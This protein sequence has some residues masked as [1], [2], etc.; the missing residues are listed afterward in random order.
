ME[1]G[2]VKGLHGKRQHQQPKRRRWQRS[3]SSTDVRTLWKT[4]SCEDGLLARQERPTGQEGKDKGRGKS[5][6]SKAQLEC[7]ICGKTGYM[8][9]DCRS[10]RHKDGHYHASVAE[11]GGLTNLCAVEHM[12]NDGLTEICAVEEIRRIKIGVDPGAAASLAKR[13]LQRLPHEKTEKT[14]TKC[15]TAGKDSKHL[16]NQGKRILHLKMEDGIIRGAKMHVTNVRRR[17]ISDGDMND[18]GQDGVLP[19]I[20]PKLCSPKGHGHGYE[21]H[22]KQGR[23]RDR[24]RSSAQRCGFPKASC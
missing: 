24:R 16:V 2:M 5:K 13:S 23:F 8:K 10:A 11:D 14:G 12:G 1:I 17:V 20:R 4:H 6:D 22:Q 7:F 18:V 15:A 3:T 9:K 19:R 21:V